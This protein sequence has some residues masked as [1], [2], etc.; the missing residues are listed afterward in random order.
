MT[1]ES[2]HTPHLAVLLAL[3]TATA[4]GDGPLLTDLDADKDGVLRGDDCNDSDP[5]VGLP[6]AL[7]HDNDGDGY[8]SGGYADGEVD[9]PRAEWVDRYGDC[10]DD[11]PDVSPDAF[12][13]CNG[14]D[15]DCDGQVDENLD[16]TWY[17]DAD[18]DGWGDDSD[19]QEGCDQ[20]TGYVGRGG[21]CDD[22][23]PAVYPGAPELVDGKDSDC[24][25][26]G[27]VLR[28]SIDLA[29]EGYA[30]VTAAVSGETAYSGLHRACWTP[31]A[32]LAVPAEGGLA[33]FPATLSG[34]VSAG[35]TTHARAYPAGLDFT[36]GIPYCCGDLNNQGA[37]DVLLGDADLSR[38]AVEFGELPDDAALYFAD[39][40]GARLGGALDLPGGGLV[41]GDGGSGVVTLVLDAPD[42]DGRIDSQHIGFARIAGAAG[43]GRA[44]AL[45]DLTGDTV[46]DLLV[47]ATGAVYLFDGERLAE[48]GEFVQRMVITGPDDFGALVA[49]APDLTGD[50]RED[51]LV[52]SVETAT[53]WLFPGSALFGEYATCSAWAVL[54]S[55]RLGSFV[56][57]DQVG[58]G[59]PAIAIGDPDDAGR[60]F[61]LN[62]LEEGEERWLSTAT[63]GATLT[64]TGSVGLGSFLFGGDPDG[65]GYEGLGLGMDP[66]GRG[67]ILWLNSLAW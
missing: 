48:D 45:G 29:A 11:D 24:D 46:P 49:M 25:E 57:L 6:V 54:H 60:V 62:A 47:G 51:F 38:V 67:T 27:D 28:G 53:T 9:C 22:S 32:E 4:C 16:D 14:V 41:L 61:L 35:A 43:F 12:E 37:S 30:L 42:Y 19:L 3:M 39:E 31:E 56:G 33:L 7:W 63:A 10:D 55:A 23:D 2:T 40:A 15:D 13:R 26:E 50:G 8:G 36:E 5:E 59:G 66:D 18:G 17:R 20:P 34:A 44:L 65:D 21:D 1:H 52:G 58:G 64:Y